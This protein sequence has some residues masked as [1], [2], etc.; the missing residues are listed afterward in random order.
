MNKFLAVA[1]AGFALGAVS[2]ASAATTSNSTTFGPTKTDFTTS[3]LTLKAF[4]TTLGTLTSVTLSMVG[5]ATVG[6]SVTN[7]ATTS[8]NFK[9]STDTQVTLNSTTASVTNLLLD[10]TTTQS[11][12]AVGAGATAVYGPF[13]PSAS[14]VNVNGT[15][16]SD[17]TA[18]PINFSASTLSATTI[19]GGG[20]NITAAVNSTA[21]GS[22][23]V[24]Y[25]YTPT[26]TPPP[27]TVP[28]PASMALLGL[29][30][31]GLGLIRR[32]SV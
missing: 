24:T 6:G 31:A 23:T 13:T 2:Q 1:V 26:P 22:V 29:G 11:Y 3:N 32:R 5:N 4:N 16:L 27:T 10:L 17:F 28:E 7:N 21:G 15:P 18:G 14:A 12:V 30:L 8:Q 19:L 9:V 20:N 25:T